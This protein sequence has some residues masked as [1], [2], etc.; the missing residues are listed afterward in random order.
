[1]LVVRVVRSAAREFSANGA[2]FLAQAIAFNAV[3]AAVPFG[4][5]LAAM[6][7]FVYGSA[8]GNAAA[9]QAIDTYAPALHDLVAQILPTIVRTRD[10]WGL[11]GLLALVWSAKNVFQ[12]L[13]YALDRSLGVAKSRHVVFETIIAVVLVPFACIVLMLASALPVAIS[14]IVRLP[15]L[16]SLRDLPEVIGYL[17]AL[18][19]VF[20]TSALLY[21]FLP[22]RKATDVRFGVPG[23]T[24]TAFGWSLAQVGFAIYT[25]HTNILQLYGAVATVFVL[26]LYVYVLATIFL[27]GAY[28]SAA[29]ERELR[30]DA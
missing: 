9:L 21:T 5:V 26:M 28:V 27:F 8:G 30:A 6:F 12:A 2:S 22:N 14:V 17:A 15:G 13:A 29:T 23:A 11:V 3:F 24:C 7:G 19:L 18:A 20:I 1:M 25:T 4:L 10:V 16:R